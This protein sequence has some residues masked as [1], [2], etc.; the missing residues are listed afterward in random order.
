MDFSTSRLLESQ[1]YSLSKQHNGHILSDDQR[2]SF[3]GLILVAQNMIQNKQLKEKN[4]IASVAK[5]VSG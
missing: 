2:K 1:C 5:I 4:L 3:K